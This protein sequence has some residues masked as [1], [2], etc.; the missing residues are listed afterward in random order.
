MHDEG[1]KCDSHSA[2][3]SCVWETALMHGLRTSERPE[4]R[5]EM[6]RVVPLI[7]PVCRVRVEKRV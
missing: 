6:A 4:P 1:L 5:L 3:Y 7:D 2:V